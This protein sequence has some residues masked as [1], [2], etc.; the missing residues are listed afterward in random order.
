MTTV[1]TGAD[2][3]RVER[4]RR[5]PSSRKPEAKPIRQ[6][7]GDEAVK[8]VQ[9]PTV[10]AAYNEEMNHVDRGDQLRSYYEYRHPL[11]RGAW[12]ALCWTFLL[13]VAL[14]NSYLLQRYGQPRWKRYTNH[15]EWRECIYNALFN[16]Y[17]HESQS[18]KRYRAGEELDDEGT[19]T[20][21]I[22]HNLVRRKNPVDCVC[23]Q[24]FRQGQV[25]SKGQKR[26]KPL[27]PGDA[28]KIRVGTR[29]W[30][31]V[32]QVALC[33]NDYCW[34]IYHNRKKA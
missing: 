6:F 31:S 9:I 32:C 33:N 13:D 24:G 8:I 16:T 34:Y 17:G 12:Q 25:R 5:K 21:P 11:R 7:F 22:E 30:C 15:R 28:N 23:C 1:F 2:D 29:Y 4:Q 20:R 26:R 14:V 19:E 27:G 10:A 18:R 3:E